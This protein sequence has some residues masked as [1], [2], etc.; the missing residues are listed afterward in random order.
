MTTVARDG[1]EPETVAGAGA[2]TVPAQRRP[3]VEPEWRGRTEIA[4]RAVVKIACCAAREVPE[5][6]DVHLKGLPWSRPS[7]AEV[8]GERAIVR[9]NV[10]VAYPAPLHAVAACLRQHVSNR[11]AYQTGLQVTRLDVIMANVGGDL[12]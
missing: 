5:V 2:V 8:H 1:R 7:S 9:L 10:S 3:P 6:R 12:P 11:I 4:G